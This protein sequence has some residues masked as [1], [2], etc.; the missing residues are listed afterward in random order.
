MMKFAL[1]AVYEP[2]S[3]PVFHFR[4]TSHR[5]S[6]RLLIMNVHVPE[7]IYAVLG[8]SIF[9]EVELWLEGSVFQ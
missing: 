9:Y 8:D 5:P 2:R 7:G 1:V 3:G 4:G 6:G